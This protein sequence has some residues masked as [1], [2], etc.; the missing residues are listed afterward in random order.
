MAGALGGMMAMVIPREERSPR[1]ACTPIIREIVHESPSAMSL[2]DALF[3]ISLT[4]GTGGEAPHAAAGGLPYRRRSLPE[5]F[6][7][8]PMTHVSQQNAMAA[9]VMGNAQTTYE[10]PRNK[11]VEQ[12]KQK[13]SPRKAGRR[14]KSAGPMH[15]LAGP[16]LKIKSEAFKP[17]TQDLPDWTSFAGNPRTPQA[18]KRRSPT[19]GI[20]K[21]KKRRPSPNPDTIM[22]NPLGNLDKKLDD[23]VAM[24]SSSF[25]PEMLSGRPDHLHHQPHQEAQHPHDTGLGMFQDELAFEDDDQLTNFGWRNWRDEPASPAI[26]SDTG[27]HSGGLLSP[28]FDEESQELNSIGSYGDDWRRDQQQPGRSQSCHELSDF[29]NSLR[30]YT[31]AIPEEPEPAM[32]APPPVLNSTFMNPLDLHSSILEEPVHLI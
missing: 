25:A 12:P 3:D 14:A 18:S 20:L 9:A 31:P 13:R 24:D 10:T 21:P 26:I 32:M 19:V 28:T 7:T 8:P 5:S 11:R 2:L 30:T 1:R 17:I 27:S 15:Q 23:Y 6:F 22:M 16:N 29:F 4:S